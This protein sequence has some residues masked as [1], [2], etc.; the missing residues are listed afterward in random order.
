[1]VSL[2]VDLRKR[3]R[4]VVQKPDAPDRRGAVRSGRLDA[5]VFDCAVRD[6]RAFAPP[7]KNASAPIA[8]ASPEFA[9]TFVEL[10]VN[11][12]L[13][14]VASL[15]AS[16]APGPLGPESAVSSTCTLTLLP[17][18]HE[19]WIVSVAE[20]QTQIAASALNR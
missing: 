15:S 18:T 17:C 9:V 14:I 7:K 5:V 3:Q 6:R 8:A 20:P 19:F 2:D 1:V 12:T 13:S 16:N 10:P 4:P 11:R